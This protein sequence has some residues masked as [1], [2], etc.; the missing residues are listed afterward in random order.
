MKKTILLRL[1][2]TSFFQNGG[3]LVA[4]AV[5]IP[6][7]IRGEELKEGV[8]MAMMAM[9]F[10]IFM[11]VNMMTYI[12]MTAVGNFLATI[13]RMST[14]YSLEECKDERAVDVE[15]KDVKVSIEACDFSWGFKVKQ[16]N[17]TGKKDGDAAAGAGRGGAGAARG[18]GDRGGSGRGG[19]GRGG[20]GGG[21]K[22]RVLRLELEEVKQPVLENISIDM[23]P[24][25]FLA[26][27]GQVG[28]GKSSLL[29]SV[30]QETNLKAGKAFIKG[31]IAYVE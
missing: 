30:M 14:V 24:G 21:P 29:Y 1:V 6:Q 27:V 5:L 10:Y 8:S 3:L 31:S 22:G 20:R 26:V 2:G 11:S 15:Q 17:E 18:G 12:A 23:S 13:E 25:N 19:G 4:L 7:W 9:V 16:D 28:C